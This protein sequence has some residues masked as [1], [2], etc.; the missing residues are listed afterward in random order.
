MNVISVQNNLGLPKY[1]QIILSIEKAIEEEKL[2]KGD[3]LPS[4]NKVCLAFSLSRDTVLQAYDE[5]KK[6]GIIYA[7]PGKGYYVKSVETTLKHRIFLLFDELNIFKEDIYNSF[8]KNI[9]KNVQVDIF[10]HHFN[11]RVFQKLIND[12]NGNYTKYIIMP[13]NLNDIVDSVK[14]LP[15]NEV[16]IL[17]QTNQNLKLYPAIYQNH[18]KDIFEGLY[19]AKSRLNKYKKLILIFPGFREPL[20]MKLGFEDFCTAYHFEYEII[21]EFTGR[22]IT[23]GDLYIIPND[24]D[25]VKVIES[26]GKQSLKL[27]SDFGIISYN[28]T[29]LKK[30]VAN[31]ITTIS[32]HFEAMG[33]ILAEMV[34]KGNKEQIENKSSLIMRNS[35]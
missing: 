1:K 27:G 32:T 28:E 18:Q 21:T 19:K 34:L 4:V 17:D 24:R 8:L 13:T 15:V 26:A 5:L 29:P 6:R 14:T 12:S 16:I 7:I 22:E 3:R 11:V 25:L 31:G 30:I 23:T 20:G 33:K 9:G 2:K 10:F 35:L